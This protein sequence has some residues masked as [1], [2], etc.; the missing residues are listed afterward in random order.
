MCKK[1]MILLLFLSITFIFTSGTYFYKVEG[2]IAELKSSNTVLNSTNLELKDE[3]V[4]LNRQL[5]EVEEE[6]VSLFSSYSSDLFEVTAYDPSYK[7]CGKWAKHKKTKTGTTP[8][9]LRTVAVDPKIIPLGSLVYIEGIGWRVAEDTG[10]LIKG[11]II[12]IYFDKYEDAKRFG[13]QKLKVY[14]TNVENNTSFNG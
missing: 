3:N 9:S 1:A 13:R 12:D 2:E 8:N 7:S 5:F 11:K 4:S 6:N 10:R 14:Y